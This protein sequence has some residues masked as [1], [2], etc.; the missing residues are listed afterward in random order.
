MKGKHPMNR[1]IWFSYITTKF[2]ELAVQLELNASQNLLSDHIHAEYFFRDLLNTV[3]N[4]WEFDNANDLAENTPGFDL[5]S[6]PRKV[7]VQISGDSSREKI[8][9][10]LSREQLEK[11]SGYR[12][13]FLFIVS[14]KP[15]YRTRSFDNPYGLDFE[16]GRDILDL[17]DL[18]GDIKGLPITPFRNVFTLVT[19]EL[20]DMSGMTHIDSTLVN[21]VNSLASV[22]LDERPLANSSVFA[23]EDKISFNDLGAIRDLIID[24]APYTSRLDD[25][26][27][28]Y[29]R[30][31]TNKTL[32]TLMRIS[33][34]YRESCHA[35]N[36][37]SD[38]FNSVVA[39]LATQIRHSASCAEISIEVL[40]L[41]VCIIVVDAFMRCKIFK[42]PTGEPHAVAN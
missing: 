3:K 12:F 14:A 21:I 19:N 16:A 5:I 11:Y 13:V 27:S 23:I 36:D 25:I 34:T 15:K 18:L 17:K 2:S 1:E 10:S 32:A 41:C 26:Y 42:R 30:S 20:G 39:E 33:K 6:V 4:D 24:H 35:Y 31:G 38:V 28:E 29:D 37:P 22:K 8:N 9:H 7:L 40:D